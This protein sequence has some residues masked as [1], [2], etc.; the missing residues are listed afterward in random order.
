[1]AV[2]CLTVTVGLMAS[3]EE[4]ALGSVWAVPMTNWLELVLFKAALIA[5]DSRPGP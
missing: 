1:M 4:A 5:V 2:P 3:P